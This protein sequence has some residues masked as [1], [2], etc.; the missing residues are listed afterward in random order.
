MMASRTP[1]WRILPVG[2]SLLWLGLLSS[3]GHAL[4]LGDLAVSSRPAPS[5]N[6]SLPFSDDKTVRLSELQTRIA[7]DAEYA[8]WGLQMPKDVRQLRIRVVPASK[9]VGY[10]ELYSLNPLTQ[11][12]F[13]LLVWASYAGQTILTRYKVVLLDMPSLIKGKTLSASSAAQ[14]Q[15]T[16]TTYAKA[17]KAQAAPVNQAPSPAL[18]ASEPGT[19][20]QDTPTSSTN[21]EA[22][23]S[24][25]AAPEIRSA[26]S[27]TPPPTAAIAA[28]SEAASEI[29][30]SPSTGTD[31]GWGISG[32]VIA[33]SAIL[34]L[35]GFLMGK[36]RNRAHTVSPAST[37]AQNNTAAHEDAVVAHPSAKPSTMTP[38]AVDSPSTGVKQTPPAEVSAHGVHITSASRPPSTALPTP[39]LLAS[40]GRPIKRQQIKSAGN[41]NIDLAK[42][43]LSMGDPSTAQMVLQQV[44]E[45]GTEVERTAARQLL[46]EMI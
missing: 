37:P 39:G 42:I 1:L 32:W 38:A 13:D 17:K 20:S 8:Q 6:A 33:S 19:S 11:D 15:Q 41:A 22:T 24:E 5:F 35:L 43:Y 46:Q 30:D 25:S 21:V 28:T 2:A 7:T 31:R 45:E 12:S 29:T 44:M 40:R 3:P 34:F 9:T 27:E 36:R 26:A 10:I 4:T 18:N 16:P 14:T 23:A